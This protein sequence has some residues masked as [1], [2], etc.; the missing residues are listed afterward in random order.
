M[1]APPV[2]LG[3][4]SRG[5]AI[6]RPWTFNV[7]A[8]L[9]R[10]PLGTVALGLV[11]GIACTAIFAGVLAPHDPTRI[12]PGTTLAQPGTIAPNGVP[13]IL[14]ADESG[15]DDGR[16]VQQEQN[17][18]RLEHRAARALEIHHRRGFG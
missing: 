15:R 9:R 10:K 6:S 16:E 13:F 8:R 5:V 18:G 14:G 3:R 1:I 2:A 12:Y 11:A 7:V 17:V 4:G